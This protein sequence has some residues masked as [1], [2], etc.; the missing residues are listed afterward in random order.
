M[1]STW[2][3]RLPSAL[4]GFLTIVSVLVLPLLPE[5]PRWLVYRD[6]HEDAIAILAVT[7]ADGDREDPAVLVTYREICDTLVREVDEGQRLSPFMLLK[8][9]Q[10]RRRLALCLSVAV[11]TM[12]SGRIPPKTVLSIPFLTLDFR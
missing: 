10:N 5:S 1:D 11:I 12:V 6:R 2:A 7:Y 4:Q 9:R 3:W 8:G